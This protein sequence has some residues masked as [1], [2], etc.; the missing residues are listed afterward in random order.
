MTIEELK[1]KDLIVFECLS[2]SHAQGLATEHSDIDIKGVFI[3][4]EESYFGLDYVEQINNES[5]DIVYYELRRFVELLSKS[6]PNIIE[7][8]YTP[9]ES[10]KKIHPCFD[11]LRQINILS[12]QCKERFGNYAIN[13]VRKAK[14]LNKKIL[15]PVDKKRKSV[16]DFCY[17]AYGQGSISIDRFL[18]LNQ[19]NQSECGVTSIPHMIDVYGIY[20]GNSEYKGLI[21]KED[22]N[23]LSLSSI[24][25][26]EE[27]IGVMHFNRS[28]Y[29]KYCKDYKE[30]WKWVN[31]RNEVRYESTIEHGKN[32][33]AKNMMHCFRLLNVC[34]E[35]G[36]T[37][38][39]NVKR[40]DREFLLGI[41]KGKY[42]YTDLVQMAE[43]KI[44][45]ID[46]VFGDSILPEFPNR[47]ELNSALVE[48]RRRFYSKG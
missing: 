26:G 6:N 17:V 36:R 41:K 20:F 14:G 44:R 1:E 29:S 27:P 34:E 46:K 30:Y 28:V 24:P 2:G 33:D 7:L 18:E 11:T 13:Q 12:K 19:L 38:K 9:D 10:V 42:E 39:I 22:A 37:G 21:R 48:V 45:S 43:D 15:N 5:N 35:I 40:D 4:P 16:L 23:E 8:L 47:E 3:L 31:E 25:K 32:Y